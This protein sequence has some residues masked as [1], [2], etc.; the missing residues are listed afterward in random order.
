[1]RR[2]SMSVI[3]KIQIKTTCLHLLELLSSKRK[4]KVL[5]RMWKKKILKP[6]WWVYADSETLKKGM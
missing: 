1:M 4:E 5:A 3:R 6:Y 2:Y